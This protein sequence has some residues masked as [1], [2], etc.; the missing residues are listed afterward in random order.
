MTI[1]YKYHEGSQTEKPVKIDTFSS[2]TAVYLRKNIQRITRI[3]EMSGEK[4][5]LWGYEEAKLTLDE[6]TA[7]LAEDTAAKVE[8]MAMMSGI[9]FEG[10]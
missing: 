7:Y 2:P 6:W 1:K 10:E 5:S 4:I 8:Y 9:D 3:D